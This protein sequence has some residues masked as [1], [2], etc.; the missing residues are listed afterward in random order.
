MSANLKGSNL[1]MLALFGGVFAH[2]RRD[3]LVR[4]LPLRCPY[5]TYYSADS[6]RNVPYSDQ[7]EGR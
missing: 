5:A 4:G 3:S 2:S 1:Q 6:H 7:S